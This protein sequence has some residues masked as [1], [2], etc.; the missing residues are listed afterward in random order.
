[1]EENNPS[2]LLKVLGVAFGL[3]IIVGNTIGVGILR[4]PGDVAAALPSSGWFIGAWIAGGIYALLGAM[5]MAELAVMIPKSGG[6]YVFARRALGEYPA[7]VIGWTDWISV[8]AA[9]AATAI[10]LG[11][12][13]GQIFPSLA[14][15]ENATALSVVLAFTAVNWVGVRSGDRTQQLLSLLKLVAL[16][17]VAVACFTAPAVAAGTVAA[18]ILPSGLAF[19][20]ALVFVFQNVLYTYD[21]W[22]GVTYFGGEIKDPAREIPRAMAYGV[23]AVLVVYLA[24][25]AAYLHVLGIGELAHDKFPAATAANV[26]FGS[27]GQSVVRIVMLV[28]LLGSVNALLM[29]ASRTPYAMSEDGLLPRFVSRVNAGGTPH[30]SL[31]ASAVVTI[32][33]VMSGT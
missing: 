31:T 13:S 24:L 19:V 30:F 20:S 12:L 16:L 4:S 15:H 1:M 27:A 6:Q 11:E 9:I 25:N 3:A 2:R 18:P 28:T 21:G 29:I 5:T 26:V 14:G 22:N 7:F 33:L 17:A 10:G 32:G 8:C 23:L